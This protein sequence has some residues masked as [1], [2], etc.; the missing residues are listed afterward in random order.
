MAAEPQLLTADDLLQMPDDGMRYELVRGELRMSPPP[1]ARHEEIA[2]SIILRVGAYIHEHE[3]G[4]F[5]GA[6]GFRIERDPDTVRA[7]DFAFI[8]AGRLPGDASPRGYPEFGPD[9]IAEVVSPS[10]RATEVQEK[11]EQ[12]LAAGVRM[13]WLVYPETRSV[14]V[15]RSP[16]NIRLLSAADTID[17]GD[18]L[19]GFTC[20]VRDLFP[21]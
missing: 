2:A 12:W 9:L 5:Y 10:D 20:L 16:T 6:P 3:L 17:G 18:V 14:A 4:R 13:A 1:G 15:Y 7:P 11:I 8:A 21:D 19:P